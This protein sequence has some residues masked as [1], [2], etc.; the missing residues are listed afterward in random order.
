MKRYS[1]RLGVKT[2]IG[3][4]AGIGEVSSIQGNKLNENAS[5]VSLVNSSVTSTD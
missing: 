5:I 2:E 1:G 3:V 4:G